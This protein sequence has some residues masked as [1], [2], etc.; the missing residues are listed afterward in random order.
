[1][2][3]YSVNEYGL[4]RCYDDELLLFEAQGFDDATTE[5][6]ENFI[7]E[8][9]EQEGYKQNEDGEWEEEHE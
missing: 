4:L 9:L 3:N 5:Q 6:I 8:C 1:M 2:I 7:D